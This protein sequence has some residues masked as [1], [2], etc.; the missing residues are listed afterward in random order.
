M[1]HPAHKRAPADVA[2]QAGTAAAPIDTGLYL[3]D[4]VFLY[5]VVRSVASGVEH[6]VELEDCY[7]LDVVRVPAS[8]LQARGL[9]VV[10]A[11][12]SA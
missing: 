8:A 3:T 2:P 12:S 1:L 6:V 11:R 9:R 10:A 5:R 4:E 7:A